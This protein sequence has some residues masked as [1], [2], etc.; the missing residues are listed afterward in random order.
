[1]EQYNHFKLSVGVC[2][3]EGEIV[4]LAVSERLQIIRDEAYLID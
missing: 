1:M 4:A 3:S 2:V